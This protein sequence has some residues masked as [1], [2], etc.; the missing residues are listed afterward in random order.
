[1]SVD[2]APIFGQFAR[3]YDVVE[4]DC[5]ADQTTS[6]L[7]HTQVNS[8][9]LGGAVVPLARRFLHP[10]TVT[11]GHGSHSSDN[12]PDI[13]EQ[14]KQRNLTGQTP[15]IVPGQPGWNPNLAS[16]SEAAI[17]AEKAPSMPL[18]ELQAQSINVIQH[19]HHDADHP[20]VPDEVVNPSEAPAIRDNLRDSEQ[21]LKDA[22]DPL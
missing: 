18:E 17:R 19:L 21:K 15:E 4:I 10:S 3:L 5:R 16:D 7:Q 14:E 1:M 2:R 11:M 6:H 8:Q 20:G 22:H 9:H 12:K 13:I